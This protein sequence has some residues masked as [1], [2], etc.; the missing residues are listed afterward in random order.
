MYVTVLFITDF[1]LITLLVAR[2]HVCFVNMYQVSE[3]QVYE[4]L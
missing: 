2:R 4:V 1:N 3:W